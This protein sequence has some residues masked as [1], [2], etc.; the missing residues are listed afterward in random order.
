MEGERKETQDIRFRRSGTERSA[1]K[2]R[3]GITSPFDPRLS[4]SASLV[5][6]W[7]SKTG[8]KTLTEKVMS[9]S[10]S[11]LARQTHGVG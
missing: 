6:L 8:R 5:C 3:L 10:L 1:T 11:S 7:K 2:G 4:V 9:L